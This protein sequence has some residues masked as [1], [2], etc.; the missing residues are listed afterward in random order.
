V[1][2]SAFIGLVLL[3]YADAEFDRTATRVVRPGHHGFPS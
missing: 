1:I 3:A 2:L